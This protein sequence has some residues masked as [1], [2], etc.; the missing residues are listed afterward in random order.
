MSAAIEALHENKLLKHENAVATAAFC[1]RF[2]NLFDVFNSSHK[3]KYYTEYQKPLRID[4]ESWEYLNDSR[5]WLSKIRI[6]GT[7]KNNNRV[8]KTNR[9]KFINGF[10]QAITATQMLLQYLKVEFGFEYLYM[11][12]LNQDPLENA[13]GRIRRLCGSNDN[14]TCRQ[15]E[16]AFLNVA[17]GSLEKLSSKYSNCEDGF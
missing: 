5:E 8:D 11:R 17:V 16:A 4:S 1:S 10:K 3:K 13:F 2:N 6:Y 12:R 15:F 9:F 14:P 7:N